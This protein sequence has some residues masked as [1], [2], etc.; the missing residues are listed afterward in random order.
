MDNKKIRSEY[1]ANRIKPV[2]SEI[3]YDKSE[4]K[5]PFDTVEKSKPYAFTDNLVGP[6]VN[7]ED[8]LVD[9]HKDRKGDF[10]DPELIIHGKPR[11]VDI[12]SGAGALTTLNY[13]LKPVKL[14]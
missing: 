13:D 2:Q 1:K 8:K 5:Y 11:T 10:N 14:T 7:F 4:P 12:T 3:V 6:K 9:P